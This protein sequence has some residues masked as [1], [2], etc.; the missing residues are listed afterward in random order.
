ME[1]TIFKILTW[2]LLITISM[3]AVVCF[4]NALRTLGDFIYCPDLA[5]FVEIIFSL[6][7]CAAC[8]LTIILMIVV[9]G[10]IL[11]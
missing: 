7:A 11:F 3:G 5:D 4:A 6:L 9:Y 2:I 1:L 10:R 8:T